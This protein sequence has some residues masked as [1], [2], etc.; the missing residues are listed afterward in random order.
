MVKR[1][2][3]TALLSSP[4]K[5]IVLSQVPKYW[6]ETKDLAIRK[7]ISSSAVVL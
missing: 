7:W 6:T 2:L 1:S 4:G 3:L 5:R